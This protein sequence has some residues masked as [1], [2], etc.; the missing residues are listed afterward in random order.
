MQ[1]D[2]HVMHLHAIGVL[3]GVTLLEF[4]PVKQEAAE[5]QAPKEPEVDGE[6]ASLEDLP[7]CPNHQPSSFLRTRS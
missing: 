3:E 2:T 4:E 5:E 7:E 6:G 1:Q